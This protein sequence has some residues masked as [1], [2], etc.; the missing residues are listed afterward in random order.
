LK[1]QLFKGVGTALVTPFK[2][3]GSVDFAAFEGLIEM[4][5]EAGINALI[6]CGTTGETPTLSDKEFFKILGR[7]A[8]NKLT[9]RDDEHGLAYGLDLRKDMA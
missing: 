4:Q 1:K 3:D 7:V 5:L 9:V 8:G 6:I 2:P